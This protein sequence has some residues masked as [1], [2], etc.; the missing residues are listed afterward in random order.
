[1]KKNV[2]RL[3]LFLALTSFSIPFSALANDLVFMADESDL[4]AFD[5]MLDKQ[6]AE[7]ARQEK[8]PVGIG[9]NQEPFGQIVREEANRI[10]AQDKIEKPNMGAFVREQRRKDSQN[11]G[12]GAGASSGS[13]ARGQGSDLRS[14][15]SEKKGGGKSQRQGGR[16]DR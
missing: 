7:K 2:N 10:S 13:S 1:M 9:K 8:R 16:R 4:S 14:I 11:R 15:V 12:R 5:Q 6:R 3:W